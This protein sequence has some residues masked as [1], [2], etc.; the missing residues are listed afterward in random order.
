MPMARRHSR[1]LRRLK[2]ARVGRPALVAFDAPPLDP[3]D[4]GAL[5]VD[6]DG[7]PALVCDRRVFTKPR[8]NRRT[9]LVRHRGGRL[10]VG[11][12]RARAAEDCPRAENIGGTMRLLEVL[13]RP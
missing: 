5:A 10:I 9:L 7:Q 3:L 2:P 8:H 6:A 13:G 4:H 1:P 11:F 12:S